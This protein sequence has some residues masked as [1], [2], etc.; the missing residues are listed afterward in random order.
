MLMADPV[1]VLGRIYRALKSGGRLSALVFGPADANLLQWLPTR[2][3]REAAG[4][5]P[6]APGEPGM[7]AL[8]EPG[9]RERAFQAAG[10]VNVSARAVAT[11]RRFASA[12]DAVR[13][14]H[15]MLPS[16]HAILRPLS[17][18]ARER[19]WTE[20][21]AALR[22]LEGPDGLVASGALLLGVGTK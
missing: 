2:I 5:P 9:H 4:L 6:L 1:A 12:A 10:F 18:P 17:E 15:D 20:I 11:S 7:F 16:V 21:E 13:S 19:A 14:L 8:G 22:P 3:A